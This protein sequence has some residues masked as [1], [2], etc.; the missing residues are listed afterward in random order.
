MKNN[1]FSPYITFN[2]EEW[3][4]LRN[5]VPMT[6]T[7]HQLHSLMGVQ[8]YITLDEASDIY[9]PLSRLLN[10]Y[11]TAY[12]QLHTVTDTFIGQRTKKVPFIIGIAGSVAVGKSTISRIIKA[13][14]SQWNSHP[15]VDILTTD[16]FLYPNEVLEQRGIMNRKGF[17]E[18]YDIKKLMKVLGDLKSGKSEVR[19][20]LYSHLTYDVLQDEEQV[21]HDPDIV[22]VEGVNVLQ[23]P[24]RKKKTPQT[25]VSDFFDFSIYIDANEDALEKWYVN[26]FMKLRDTAFQDERSYFHKYADLTNDEASDTAKDIW[27]RINL[28]NLY[29]NILPTKSR[30]DLIL[31][32][33]GDHLIDE[34][35]LRKI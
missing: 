21:F 19:A 15:N 20:P 31:H 9:L 25:F 3:S 34:I 11:T 10:L 16:G 22:I 2:K 13:L 1:T 33:D 29:E 6:L 4:E 28:K 12:Q 24:K 32:K 27:G 18:S 5:N 23:T 14:L 35:H 17:P 26:R 30:A 7:E 8:D